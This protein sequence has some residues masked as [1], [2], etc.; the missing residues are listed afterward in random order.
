[1][2]K[3]LNLLLIMAFLSVF[4]VLG[5]ENEDNLNLSAIGDLLAPSGLNSS[6]TNWHPNG[7]ICRESDLITIGVIH[8]GEFFPLENQNDILG[9]V[10][11]TS[12]RMMEARP[13]E[14]GEL[15]LTE[16]EGEIIMICG[17]GLG[18]GWIYS[19]RVVD[20]AG[21]ILTSIVLKVFEL[22]KERIAQFQSSDNRSIKV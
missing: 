11:L 14:T 10:R 18:G 17:H 3:I 9:P 5:R 20:R 12:I 16:Y 4:T 7:G 15:R 6:N 8:N 22:E 13:P 21:P 2:R 1:M 19:V